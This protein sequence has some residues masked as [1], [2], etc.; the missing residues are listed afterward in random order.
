MGGKLS[1]VQRDSND[2]GKTDI[3]EIYDEGKLQRAGV[4]LD[5]DGRVDRWDRD[6]IALR[7]INEKERREAEAAEKKAAEEEE[8]KKQEQALDGGVTDARV[9]ARR[10]E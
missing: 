7:E 6:E 10:R 3:W 2:D 1:R 8:K 4:D 9:S 5:K